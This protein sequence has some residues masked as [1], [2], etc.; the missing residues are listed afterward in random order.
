LQNYYVTLSLLRRWMIPA[1][2]KSLIILGII[3]RT[4]VRLMTL[5]QLRPH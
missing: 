4:L 3:G 2:L 5:N 1:D